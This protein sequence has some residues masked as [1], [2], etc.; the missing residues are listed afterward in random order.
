MTL[1]LPYPELLIIPLSK[2][3]KYFPSLGQ[4]IQLRIESELVENSLLFDKDWYLAQ[5]PDVASSG[6]NP[7]T[8]F[9][10]SGAQEGRNPSALFNIEWYVTQY[11]D[12]LKSSVNPLVH[13][14]IK[15][16]AKGYH[17]NPLFDTNWYLQHYP[18]A[19]EAIN[20][21][22]HYV[23]LGAAKN[24]DPSPFFSTKDYLYQCPDIELTKINLLAHYF[25]RGTS[26]L[27]KMMPGAAANGALTPKPSA[28]VPLADGKAKLLFVGHDASATGA[29][30][31]L[32]NVIRS[33]KE[34][35]GIEV[36]IILLTGGP[37]ERDYRALG[38]TYIVDKDY[39][40]DKD[41]KRFRQLV[42]SLWN[43][44]YTWAFCNT[45]VTGKCTEMLYQAGF[46]I[47]CAI[48]EMRSVISA[49]KIEEE[50]KTIA[51]YAH[52]VIFPANRVRADFE[53]IGG[54]LGIRAI[55][56]PQ[57]LLKLPSA[58]PCAKER[59]CELLHIP[60]G[61]NLIVAAGL[62]DLRKGF[63][64][65]LQLARELGARD[66]RYHFIWVGNIAHTMAPWF[67]HDIDTA[68]LRRCFH[69]MPYTD[70]LPLYFQ[71]ADVFV[72]PSREDPF[73]NVVLDAL[74]VGVPVV[75]FDDCGG[76]V[77]LL[78]SKN[79]GEL[80]PYGD[81]KAMA[82]ATERVTND[83]AMHT[84]EAKKER[85]AYILSQYDF[86][87]Y[88]ARILELFADRIEPAGRGSLACSMLSH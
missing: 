49:L 79:N 87:H 5:Y 70:E 2:W 81:I 55:V 76:Y 6:V 15:G 77:D 23:S 73:P 61:S 40:D 71:S 45:A 30:V 52:K 32:L 48:H 64:L 28:L 80:V 26:W 82:D 18:E 78:A 68:I 47:V 19:A 9:L 12:A 17:P 29:P 10:L 14:L 72:L 51:R 20:P 85:E 1:K 7:L 4:K 37:L 39:R 27:A 62:G 35:F 8:H 86:Q 69:H 67:A 43:S 38:T 24:Y 74:V 57:G 65:Y 41:Y 50:C 21:L 3:K 53:Q 11:P 88:A 44:G 58:V 16:A 75:A 84:I 22:T 42:L 46:T 31:L 54:A 59:V 13:Y 66:S 25:G 56:N 83:P 33:L 63:D 34:S 36:A 60:P